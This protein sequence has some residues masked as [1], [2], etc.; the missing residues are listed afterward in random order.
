MDSAYDVEEIHQHS[1][2]LGHV[3]LID[4]NPR[5]DKKMKEEMEAEAKARKTLKWE[6]S[7]SIR[8]NERSTVERGNSRLKLGLGALTVRV[9]GHNKVFCHLMF[10]VLTL[11]AEQLLR[12]AT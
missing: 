1:R 10:G 12:L 3:P 11:A 6:P 4:K 9:R 5:G 2:S 7:E 8:Y